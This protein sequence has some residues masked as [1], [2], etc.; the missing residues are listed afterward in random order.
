M[1]DSRKRG[2][3]LQLILIAA[4]FLGPLLVAAWLYLDGESLRPEGRANHGT[5]LEPIV[6][7]DE[8]LPGSK[9]PELRDGRWLLVYPYEGPCGSECRQG[10]Y[11]IRQLR[12]MLGGEMERMG[13]I[14]LHGET[15][16]DTVFLANEH[17]GLVALEDGEL[18]ELLALRKP[19][20]AADGGYY[21][22]DPHGN[23]I[24]YFAPDL[25]PRD[26]VADIERLLR[27]SRI[28]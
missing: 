21:L 9:L 10:L 15:P 3:R 8:A 2:G 17:E 11:T 12:L 6:N 13:R 25:A 27:L 5:L 20:E 22:V 19:A 26:I 1:D 28:G 4:L 16:P 14:F 23:L 18:S 24:L 7:L